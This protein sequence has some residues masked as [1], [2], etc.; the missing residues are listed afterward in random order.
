M[1]LPVAVGLPINSPLAHTSAKRTGSVPLS[2]H[3][4]PCNLQSALQSGLKAISIFGTS[5]SILL[6]VHLH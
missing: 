5:P 1:H 3:F 4:G 6:F 2:L